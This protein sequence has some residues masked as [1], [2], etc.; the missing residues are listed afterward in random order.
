MLGN[1]VV[2]LADREARAEG[3]HPGFDRRVLGPEE[4]AWLR[5]SRQPER[6]RW[7]LWAAKESAYKAA[8]RLDPS[9]VFSPSR[10]AV[11][12]QSD[13]RGF[14]GQVSHAAQHFSVSVEVGAR[15]VHAVSRL[16]PWTGAEPLVAVRVVPGEG[17]LAP[18]AASAEVR[19]LARRA[20]A[21]ALGLAPAAFSFD[22]SGRLPLLRVGG[23]ES[24]SA[25]SFSHH[26]RCAAFS[27][28]LP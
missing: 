23:R 27:V 3:L 11:R 16:E 10:F 17:A 1:D 22:R 15:F 26:G 4:R 8:R 12:L 7:V 2:D 19:G 28:A 18:S 21:V 25:L 9:V 24:G 20:L 6:D 13:P 14:V 5:E